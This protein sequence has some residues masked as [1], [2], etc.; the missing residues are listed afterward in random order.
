MPQIPIEIIPN[1]HPIFVH[2]TIG[3]LTLALLFYFL[4]W[5]GRRSSLY[6]QWLAA[7]RWTLWTGAAF[8]IVT[9]YFG[10]RAF[11]TV[12]HDEAAHEVMIDHRNLA[13]AT[14]AVVAVLVLWSLLR[15]R[16]Q[17]DT[18]WGF[19]ILLLIAFG[20][21]VATG[22]HGGELV[23]RHGLGVLSLPAVGEHEHGA[24][25]M[26]EHGDEH[27]HEHATPAAGAAGG[28]SHTAPETSGAHEEGHEHSH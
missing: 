2:I 28:A 7:A 8:A 16:V 23:Y 18:G 26:H 3:A 19:R 27:A 20:L 9:A 6:E 17:G 22:W 25:H 12:E 24:G 4:T 5:L 11:N 13:L 15:R 1:W 14:I 10:W 21:L